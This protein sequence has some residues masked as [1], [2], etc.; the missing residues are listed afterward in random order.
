MNRL[1][2]QGKLQK[3][4][5]SHGFYIDLEPQI[6]DTLKK[7]TSL[8]VLHVECLSSSSHGKR[9]METTLATLAHILKSNTT[10]CDILVPSWTKDSP[11]KDGRY[12]YHTTRLNRFGRHRA[13]D[14][15]TTHYDLVQ[16]LSHVSSEKNEEDAELLS[17]PLER[18]DVLYGLLRELPS[19]WCSKGGAVVS[20]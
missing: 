17:T 10:L 8:Q 18:L 13:S 11:N 4:H 1:L 2:Q 3:L 19:L 15:H 16:I 14:I 9:T 12:I 6:V 20:S 7:N 5:V